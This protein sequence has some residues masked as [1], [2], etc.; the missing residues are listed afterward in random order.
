M[1]TGNPALIKRLTDLLEP[2]VADYGLELA[3]LQF[4]R[5]APGWVLRLVL[6]GEHGVGIDEC[7]RV[8]R[9]VSHLLEVEDPIEQPFHLEV[10][11]PGLDRPLK[12][13]RDYQRCRGKKAKIVCRQ[14]LDEQTVFIGELGELLDGVVTI[15]T[16]SGPTAI[17]LENIR[18][19]RLVVEW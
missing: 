2:V 3:E 1:A 4:R 17:P 13:E 14:P 12:R 11:S 18:R 5:E 7:A 19:A 8:S 16:E 6:D 15:T 9:E 10:S